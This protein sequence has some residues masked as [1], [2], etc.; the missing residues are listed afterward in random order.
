M[1]PKLASSK[2]RRFRVSK[3]E[4]GLLLVLLVAVLGFLAFKFLLS[5]Q[6]GVIE[7]LKEEKIGYE[8]ELAKLQAIVAKENY[9]NKEWETLTKDFRQ[10]AK[11]YYQKPDQPELIHALN[12]I[13][14]GGKLEVSHLS[15]KDEETIEMEGVELKSLG[16]STPF[17]GTYDDLEIFLS[18]LRDN[19]KRLI[20]ENLT[21]T[22][23]E[24]D[25]VNGQVSFNAFA[26]GGV[27]P[28]DE[29]Y[30][31][32][33]VF[34]DESKQNPFA[35]FDG[36]VDAPPSSDGY[37]DNDEIVKRT[38]LADLENDYIYFM[39]TAASV[40]GKVNRVNSPK[41]GKT[42]IRTEYFLST[43]YKEERAYVVL[44][45]Q[46]INL[47]FPPNQ[48]GIWAYSYGYSPVT[49]GMR[50]QDL[51]GRKI[52]VELEKGVGWKGW[53]FISATPPQDVNLYP[54]C[55]DR[56]YM[57][58]GP[59]RDDYGVLLFDRIEAE[60]AKEEEEEEGEKPGYKFYVVKPGDT[61]MGIS[62]M[63]YGSDSYY[64]KI[65]KDN[66]ITDSTVLEAGKVLVIRN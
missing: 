52:D 13:I 18:Q 53:K 25:I 10:I 31:Y 36:Y 57:E 27:R 19:E 58:L 22:K 7:A 37:W 44:D 51:D 64:L 12:E 3:R 15:F 40:T 49:V 46:N 11:K 48:V 28:K 60:Y 6:A 65:M 54:L 24:K 30:F 56:I 32:E 34:A 8:D 62:R 9:L 59:N 47:K 21:I 55:L 50:F 63:F 43:D 41:Y 5:P 42:S 14:D 38:V 20:V 45:N 16:V 23:D 66:G 26:Y 2:P 17:V 1:N 61:L 39:G 33:N 29:G 35:A 4:T